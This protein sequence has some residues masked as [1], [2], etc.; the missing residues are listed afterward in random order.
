MI[1]KKYKLFLAIII[2][3]GLFLFLNFGYF[4]VTNWRNFLPK[5]VAPLAPKPELKIYENQKIGFELK[6]P[7]EWV[8]VENENAVEINP[9]VEKNPYKNTY[10]TISSRK[11]FSSLNEVKEVLSNSVVFTPYESGEIKGFKYNDGGSHEVFWFKDKNTIYV[12]RKYSTSREA[13]K[14]FESLKF[15]E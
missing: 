6:Y 7:P 10:F 13:D 8:I 4:I 15:Y 3:L 11:E 2:T 1:I 12:I 5:K 9:P 14:I